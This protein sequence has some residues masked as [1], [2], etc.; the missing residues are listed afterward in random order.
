M[1]AGALYDQGGRPIGKAPPFTGPD[2]IG[3]FPIFGHVL[4]LA[5]EPAARGMARIWV[6]LIE[7]APR[8]IPARIIGELAAALDH[9][10]PIVILGSS[11]DAVSAAAA[12]VLKMA[13]GYDA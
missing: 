1:S 6:L 8:L 4:C 3:R 10:L 5:E 2:G 11:I 7:G 12:A 13:G 9:D